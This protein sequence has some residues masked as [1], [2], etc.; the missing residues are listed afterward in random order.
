MS[1]ATTETQITSITP[2]QEAKI[3]GYLEKFLS[4]GLSTAPQN[5]AKAEDAIRASYVYFNKTNPD[6]YS[7]N[8]EFVWAP[9]PIAGSILAAQFA[10]GDMK[11]TQDEVREQ[12]QYASYGSFEAY[13]VSTYSFIAHELPVKKDELIDITEEIIKECGVYWTFYDLVIC[14]PKPTKIHM[15]DKKLHN[16]DG[17]ALAYEDGN[18]LYAID[19]VRKS[20]LMA[21]MLS[22][23][24]KE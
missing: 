19:G 15:V 4:I 22:S 23:L 17:L 9:N 20:S 14:T 11:V 6:D 7:T 21:A 16:P 2:E 12:A 3:P 24:H 10:K 1:T 5:R 18:G 8:P 13:W